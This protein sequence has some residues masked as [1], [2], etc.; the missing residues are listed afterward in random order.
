MSFFVHFSATKY[1]KMPLL[2]KFDDFDAC[3]QVYA[4]EAKYCYVKTAI[5]PDP[6]S[7]LYNYIVEYS[8][9]QKQHFRH[10]KLA[11]GICINTCEELLDQ[12]NITQS[13]EYFVP[14]FE[15][16]YKVLKRLLMT[17]IN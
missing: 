5:K 1:Y 13:D 16:D 8:S 15:L 12:M 2:N 11:R 4:A 3:M 7:D 17:I 6:S 9:F 14:P 10:D